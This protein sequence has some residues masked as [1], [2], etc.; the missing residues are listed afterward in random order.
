MPSPTSS[1]TLTFDMVMETVKALRAPRAGT[2]QLYASDILPEGTIYSWA[3]PEFLREFEP[4]VVGTVVGHPHTIEAAR[5]RCGGL[6]DDELAVLLWD[7]AR[8][9]RAETP[10]GGASLFDFPPPRH[11]S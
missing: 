1:S 5:A 9:A 2:I 11:A 7:A 10:R 4:K 8:G 6:P 3:A